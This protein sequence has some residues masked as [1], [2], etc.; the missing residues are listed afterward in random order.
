[1]FKVS[2]LSSVLISSLF[3]PAV[4]SESFQ[5]DDSNLDISTISEY[6]QKTKSK[7]QVTSV[8]Q[9]SD[10]YPTDWA[11]QALSNLVE[12]YGCV[13]GYPNGTFRGNK[14]MTRYEAAALLNACLDRIT[15]ITD[16]L[17]RLIKEFERELAIIRGRV[18]GIEARVGEL[19]AT[20][21]STT[22]KLK[23]RSV[24]VLGA[25]NYGDSDN[26]NLANGTSFVYDTKLQFNTSFTGKDM[27][28]TRLRTGNCAASA[29]QGQT[30]NWLT[31]SDCFQQT[32]ISNT[33]TVERL[34][35]KFPLGKDFS[36]TVGA[37]VRQDDM[38]GIWPSVYPS[39]P[40]L[41]VFTYAGQI[42]AYN[43][44]LGQGMGVNWNPGNFRVSVLYVAA[45][46]NIG[47]S[48]EGGMFNRNSGS[49]TSVQIGYQGDNWAVA[50]IYSKAYNG[51]IMFS[52]P[53]AQYNFT[54]EG[55][56]ANNWGIG[57]Y[58]QPSDSGWVPSISAGVGVNHYSHSRSLRKGATTDTAS[59]YTGL[60]WNNVF[61]EGNDLG[62]AIGQPTYV[63]RE[64][65]DT[66][67]DALYVMEGY[68]K[69]QVT[70]NIS[71]TPAVFYVSNPF[72][73][74]SSDRGI[75]SSFGGILK[76]GF[77]F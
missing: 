39:E 31:L 10:V 63:I 30:V 42:G 70:D 66:P 14:A 19:E 68:Y 24:F 67:D 28:T 73:Q 46:G 72:G 27:L 74:Q 7:D 50:G 3:A 44:T 17:R 56:H 58:W 59:W 75:E 48:G 8:S 51:S 65:D 55:G 38:L 16:E 2:L 6:T 1:M 29:F 43:V 26:E 32:T 53:D 49:S 52:T 21:F 12:R 11:Y 69:F 57:G 20:Q 13:A 76:T 62:F 77:S 34:H 33:L 25:A 64:H 35:Y 54:N 15:E 18:D 37:V 22:T 5:S 60:V 45:N 47:D 71:V 23:G 9:F 36:A 4:A 40:I 41:G 61:L